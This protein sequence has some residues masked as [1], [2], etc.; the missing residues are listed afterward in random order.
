NGPTRGFMVGL[1]SNVGRRA[2]NGNLQDVFSQKNSFDFK[3]SRPLWEGAKIDL[4][5]KVGWSLNKTTSLQSDKDGN[6]TVQNQTASGTLTRSFLSLPPTLVFSV[7]KSGIKKVSELYDPESEDQ[8]ANLS[9]AFTDGFETFPIFGRLG[10]L[11][12]LSKYIPRPNWRLTWDGL[13]KIFIFKAVAK[14][15]T[16]DHSYSSGYTEG[17]RLSPDGKKQIQTQKIEYAFSPLA[18]FNITFGELWGGNIIGSIKYGVRTNYDLGLSTKNITE[19]FSKDIGV[20]AG[21]SK[22]GFEIPLFGVSLKNDIEF[23]F[24]YTSSQNSE[25]IFDM[26]D[27]NEEGKPQNG[28]TRVTLEPRVKYTISSKV[29]LSI[30]YRRSSVTPEG[31]SRIP[32][33]TTNEAG[34]DVHIAIQGN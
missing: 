34:L 28:T 13:E 12:D 4:T 29:T 3:T 24:S 26:D 7:F 31:A 9:Q 30:F 6:V 17:W 11:K 5:W 32:P 18:G 15:V 20:T 8:A 33:T 27:F 23:S 16:L 22:S 1:S 25:I 21:F 2:P 10:F 14:K 19:T